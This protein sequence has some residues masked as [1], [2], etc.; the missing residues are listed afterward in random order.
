MKRLLATLLAAA[1]TAATAVTTALAFTPELTI[2][3][4]AY[5]VMDIASG[6]VL[7]EKN[8]D[9]RKAPASITKI[10]TLALALQNG[11]INDVITVSRPAV[12][13]PSGS[14]HIALEVGEQVTFQDV[15][16]GTQLISA[17]DAANVLAEY[18]AGS[19]ETFVMMMNN[20]IKELNLSGSHFANPNG[21]DAK[22]HYVTAYDMAQI[23]RYAL[24]V[25]G[26]REVFSTTEYQMPP[27]NRKSRDYKFLAQDAIMFPSNKE[28]YEGVTGSKLGYTSDAN[29]TLVATA[30][31]GSMELVVV[32]LDS[33]GAAAK[34]ED[35]KLLLDYCFERYEPMTIRGK[36]LRADAIPIASAE[37]PTAMVEIC[38]TVD[39]SFVVPLGTP[40][41]SLQIR[42]D[43][44]A[45]YKSER[46]VTP[47]FSVCLPNGKVLY[48][49]PL[50][51][52]ILPVDKNVSTVP[53]DPISRENYFSELMAVAFKCLL[54]AL[55][56]SF[57]LFLVCRIV[58]MVNYSMGRR[59]VT[60]KKM[61]S[62]HRREQ[63]LRRRTE[64]LT[65]REILEHLKHN[66]SEHPALHLAQP[67]V[68]DNVTHI[69]PQRNHQ[70]RRTQSRK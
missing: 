13:L 70:L 43:L 46:K 16:M 29:H 6:Q 56:V 48:T 52:N 54:V 47:S 1:L 53:T 21:L 38:S 10:L 24:S 19:M 18:T 28:Y 9:K 5:V 35:A 58:I 33:V 26:F 14:T 42:Y 68:V 39:H 41:S 17:N 25:P 27:S 31:R 66:P 37:K 51:Y 60:H 69:Y 55:G 20:K 44:P 2:K 62:L 61:Q 67:P 30:K 11:K 12:T 59:L 4:D 3:S 8:M 45:L 50:E 34:F 63:A 40:R 57:L 32:A 36:E 64:E 23:T 15:V 49:A 65:Q 22:N 7:I